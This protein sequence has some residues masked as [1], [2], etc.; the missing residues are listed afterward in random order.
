[1]NMNELDN[2]IQVKVKQRIT[3]KPLDTLY[4]D[5]Y[6]PPKKGCNRGPW[7]KLVQKILESSPFLQ[8][9]LGKHIQSK[10]LRSMS[11]LKW[12]DIESLDFSANGESLLQG[13]PRHQL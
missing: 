4:M 1:M 3:C 2:L 11:F 12:C 13:G 6:D 8:G 5:L 10:L 7:A 9:F